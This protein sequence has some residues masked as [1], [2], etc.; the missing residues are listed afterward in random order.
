MIRSALAA[1]LLA[2]SAGALAAQDYASGQEAYNARDW[3]AAEELWVEEAANGSAEALLGLGNLLDFGL[4]GAFDPEGAFEKYRE[5]AELGNA[6]A[7]F[8]LGAMLD[9]GVGTEIDR[10]MAAA[11]YAMSALGEFPRAQYNLGLLYA[12]GEGIA[13]NAAFAGFWLA[14]AGADVPAAL[15]RLETLEVIP[16]EALAAPDP[17]IFRQMDLDGQIVARAAWTADDGPAGTAYRIE[18]VDTATPVAQRRIH[19]GETDGSA[20]DVALP[21]VLADP[22]WRVLQITER[23]YAP[24][25][26]QS[27]NGDARDD[28]APLGIVRFEVFEGDVRARGYAE[29]IG[30]SLSRSGAIVRYDFADAPIEASGVQHRF[31][32]DLA[33]ATSVSDFL[34]GLADGSVFAPESDLLPGEINVRIVF[35]DATQ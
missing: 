4:T 13:G 14:K 30:A 21:G 11:W 5:A 33:F 8:N 31:D 18:I 24:S 20:I 26:W 9:S 10:R 17:L 1:L 27:A 2:A 6:E 32:R 3:Q 29:R 25:G 12:D 34:P 35:S 28:L 16:A 23:D 7:A 19:M 15:E 22:A